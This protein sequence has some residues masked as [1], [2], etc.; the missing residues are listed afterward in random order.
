V[1]QCAKKNVETAGGATYPDILITRTLGQFA[2]LIECGTR[3][4]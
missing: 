1:A 3:R 2:L 4:S